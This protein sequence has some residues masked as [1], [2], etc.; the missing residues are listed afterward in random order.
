MADR[1][2]GEGHVWCWTLE[3]RTLGTGGAASADAG[4]IEVFWL[5]LPGLLGRDATEDGE[6][7]FGDDWETPVLERLLPHDRWWLWWTESSSLRGLMADAPLVRRARRLP[8]A[9]PRDEAAIW[10]GRGLL[11]NAGAALLPPRAELQALV[12]QHGPSRY[13]EIEPNFLLVLSARAP[14]PAPSPAELQRGFSTA[15]PEAPGLELLATVADRVLMQW[16]GDLYLGA[17]RHEE[18]ALCASLEA[19][20]AEFGVRVER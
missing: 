9:L 5:R 1:T 12:F 19:W 8:D 2:S 13:S 20:A 15:T 16:N 3:H 7:V 17:R 11:A 10:V 14:G 18:E 4:A 6:A